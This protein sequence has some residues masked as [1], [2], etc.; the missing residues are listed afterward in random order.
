MKKL[1]IVPMVVVL[2]FLTGCAS[3]PDNRIEVNGFYETYDPVLDLTFIQHPDL[4]FDT[5]WDIGNLKSWGGKRNILTEIVKI[6]SENEV[7]Y[8]IVFEAFY[9][10]PDWIF[11]DRAL[12]LNENNERLE[13]SFDD[14][15][16]NVRGGISSVDEEERIVINDKVD[17]L[18]NFLESSQEVSCVFLGKSRTEQMPLRDNAKLA[19]IETINK[20]IEL[21]TIDL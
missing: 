16:R 1:V 15:S 17:D 21:K 18:K 2:L 5:H 7:I 14:V 9:R 6:E 13:F 10:S 12:L 3:I 19:I 11:M 8:A 20:Y 4:V